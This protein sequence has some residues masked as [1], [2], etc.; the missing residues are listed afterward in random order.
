MQRRFTDTDEVFAQAAITRDAADNGEFFL[1][2]LGA[3]Q[4]VA[5]HAVLH[6]DVLERYRPRHGSFFLP[7]VYEEG[8]TA[9]RILSKS[10]TRVLGYGHYLKR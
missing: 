3:G 1:A 6:G 10:V 5:P 8:R 4:E 9:C 2:T 7:D